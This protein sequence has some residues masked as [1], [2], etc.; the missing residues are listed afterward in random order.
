MWPFRKPTAPEPATRPGR[1]EVGG[2]WTGVD[3]IQRTLG[4][5]TTTVD[6]SAFE[7]DLASRSTTG[8][9]V[10]PGAASG[11]CLTGGW[12]PVTLA[13]EGRRRWWERSGRRKGE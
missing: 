3:P 1:N 13:L 4:P 8:A 12:G 11:G 5:M 10:A 2:E 6:T 7:T 9:G